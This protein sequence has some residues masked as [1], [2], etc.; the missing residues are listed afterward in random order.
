MRIS[1]IGFLSIKEILRRK[2]FYVLLILIVALATWMYF[3]DLSTPGSGRFAKHVVMQVVWLVSIVL[4]ATISARQ[5]PTDIEQKSIYVLVARPIT[6]QQY[7]VG[8]ILG[9]IMASIAC[10]VSLFIVLIIMLALKGSADLIDPSLWQAFILQIACLCVICSI[11]VLLS[12]VGT[13]A[14]AITLMLLIY[15]GMRYWGYIMP[16]KI[17]SLASVSKYIAWV[18]YLAMPH[19]EFMDMSQRVVHSWGPLP[20]IVFI[21]VLLYCAIY[22]ILAGSVA[23]TIFKRRWL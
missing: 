18:I 7:V 15:A 6:R 14:G 10:F 8:R 22:S 3:L 9:S 11:T 21:I 17:A 2:E 1:A 4:A 23:A 19:F 13:S 16:D 12:I 5:I 20:F